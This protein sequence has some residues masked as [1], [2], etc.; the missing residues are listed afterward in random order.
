MVHTLWLGTYQLHV[1]IVA[2]TTTAAGTVWLVALVGGP[3]RYRTERCWQTGRTHEQ[4]GTVAC[5]WAAVARWARN[6]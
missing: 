2:L 4:T 3:S 5:T 1:L 6:S